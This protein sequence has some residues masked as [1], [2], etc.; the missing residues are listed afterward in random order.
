MLFLYRM[1]LINS[2]KRDSLTFILF[3]RGQYVLTVRATDADDG[4]NGVLSYYLNGS[5]T[6]PLSGL[7]TINTVTGVITTA[8][9]LDAETARRHAFLVTAVDSAAYG[10]RK[11]QVTVTVDGKLCVWRIVTFRRFL[12]S[13]RRAFRRTTRGLF[14]DKPITTALWPTNRFSHFPVFQC[15]MWTTTVLCS[16]TTWWRRTCLVRWGPAC[17]WRAWVRTILTKAWMGKSR[18]GISSINVPLK[19]VLEPFSIALQSLRLPHGYETE[20]SHKNFPS[21]TKL[22]RNLCLRWSQLQTAPCFSH[23]NT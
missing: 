5:S 6:E 11:A 20:L 7:F 2:S 8:R 10:P 16:R 22:A 18:T 13:L 19:R 15:W 21:R 3:F 9:T 17:W 23:N 14:N 1:T 4:L 12:F